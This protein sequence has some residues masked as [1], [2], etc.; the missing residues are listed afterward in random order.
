MRHTDA[1]TYF[2]CLPPRRRRLRHAPPPFHVYI[3]I[4]PPLLSSARPFSA[5]TVTLH[6]VTALHDFARRPS[7][8]TIAPAAY[9]GCRRPR[10]DRQ[11]PRPSPVCPVSPLFT[12]RL[13]ASISRISIVGWRFPAHAVYFHFLPCQD[14]F[15]PIEGRSSIDN[16][17]CNITS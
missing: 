7:L 16:H 6:A 4:T 15:T 3:I 9:A 2:V 5:V 14:A 13:A 12:L 11:W 17:I 1:I 10:F 8:A